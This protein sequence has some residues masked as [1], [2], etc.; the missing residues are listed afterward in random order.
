MVHDLVRMYAHMF[1]RNMIHNDIDFDHIRYSEETERTALVDFERVCY[2]T[3]RGPLSCDRVHP[4]QVRQL[5]NITGSIC[6]GTALPRSH[7]F[8]IRR[9]A[10]NLDAPAH[11]EPAPGLIKALGRCP[12]ATKLDPALLSAQNST[13]AGRLYI[14]LR[15][16][17][18]L[19]GKTHGTFSSQQTADSRQ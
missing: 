8:S 7:Q 19:S 6:E 10:C 2:C 15:K 16:W 1:V 5:L 4:I 11:L 14:T 17:S 3:T 18:T 13:E 12:F 9:E